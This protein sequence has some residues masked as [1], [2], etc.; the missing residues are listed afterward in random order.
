MIK[1]IDTINN[2]ISY[3]HRLELIN[4]LNQKIIIEN[5]IVT[6][7][8]AIDYMIRSFITCLKEENDKKIELPTFDFKLLE[9]KTEDNE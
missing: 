5:K 1:N 2:S 9:K 4:L 7:N 6:I 3:N 8:R